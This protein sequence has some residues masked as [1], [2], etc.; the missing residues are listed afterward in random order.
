[1][2]I[3][4]IMGGLGNQ[5]FIYAT[6]H[7]MARRANTDLRLSLRFFATYDHANLPPRPYAL[8]HFAITARPMTPFQRLRVLKTVLPAMP[9]RRRRLAGRLLPVPRM[10]W[11]DDRMLGDDP[12]VHHPARTT[13]LTGGWQSEKLFGEYRDDLLRE[14]RFREPPTGRN[15]ELAREIAGSEAIAVHFRR[16]DYLKAET[17]TKPCSPD[18]YRRALQTTRAAYPNGRY[19]IFTDDPDWVR[20]HA[21]LPDGSTLVSHNLGPASFEDMRLMSL[22]RHFVIANST[23]SWWGAWLSTQPGK[24]VIAPAIWYEGGSSA[25]A[26]LVPESWTRM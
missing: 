3:A 17:Q 12:R 6:G 2:I 18:Y 26:D 20:A 9:D 15:A 19:F 25:E 11:V 5:M 4:A 1:V 21:D 8:D 22:C 7:A 13:L 14:F 23:F 16:T 10:A 24:T